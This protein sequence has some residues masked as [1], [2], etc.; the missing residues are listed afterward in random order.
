MKKL[1]YLL[2]VLLL[3]A[4]LPAQ[5]G[6]GDRSVS[7]LGWGNG[8]FISNPDPHWAISGTTSLHYQHFLFR[9]FSAGMGLQYHF[10]RPASYSSFFIMP[11]ARYYFLKG[12][13]R[14]YVYA[15]A[16]TGWHKYTGSQHAFRQF[17]FTTEFGAGANW[18]VSPQWSIEGRAGI[19]THWKNGRGAS[20]RVF[21][22]GV[23]YSI[24]YK[25]SKKKVPKE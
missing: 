25:D 5:T 23:Q 6:K 12:P 9:N 10:T 3:P 21:K 14:P 20:S 17:P 11:E 15:A 1:F 18:F 19:N 7:L 13:V 8:T 2:C 24:P 4:L 22:I 16:G